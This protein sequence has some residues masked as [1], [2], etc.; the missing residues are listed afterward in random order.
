M[1]TPEDTELNEI[2]HK[3]Y[4]HFTGGAPSYNTA[5]EAVQANARI[6]TNNIMPIILDLITLH[7]KNR[8]LTILNELNQE[9]FFSTAQ[10]EGQFIKNILIGRIDKLTNPTERSE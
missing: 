5:N 7:T 3:L 6:E 9:L 1:T 4:D 2:R 8:A 10:P